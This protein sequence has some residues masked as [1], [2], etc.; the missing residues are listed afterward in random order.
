VGETNRQAI[1]ER[2][3]AENGWN[4]ER[5]VGAGPGSMPEA[6]VEIA[7]ALPEW[8]EMLGVRAVCDAGCGDGMWQPTLPGYHGVDI[9]PSVVQ[10]CRERFPWRRYTVA[11]FVTADLPPLD[12]VLC[13]DALQHLSFDDGLAA[14]A[15]FRRNGARVLFSSSHAGYT[16]TNVQ[17]GGWFPVNLEA[18]PFDLGEPILGVPDTRWAGRAHPWES[19]IFG[20]WLL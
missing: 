17:T 10:A 2:I 4:G 14:I 3:Y 12:A 8:C 5:G 13:R 11:D 19:K 20:A 9:V 18:F 1:F 16:N 7:A 6:T 15:N